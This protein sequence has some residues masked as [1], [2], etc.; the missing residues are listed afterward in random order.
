VNIPVK[1]ATLDNRVNIYHGPAQNPAGATT[2]WK[3][4][5][6]SPQPTISA[7]TTTLISV[8]LRNEAGAPWFSALMIVVQ[9]SSGA[10]IVGAP[11]VAGMVAGLYT[12]SL[13]GTQLNAGG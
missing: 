5:Y 1:G 8:N 9:D 2:A 3:I 10:T 4:T 12:Y 11:M 13:D 7:D 6:L